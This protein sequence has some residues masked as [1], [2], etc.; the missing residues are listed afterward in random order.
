[1]KIQAVMVAAA[2]ACGMLVLASGDEES[3]Q[4]PNVLVIMTDEHNFRTLGCYRERL[5]KEEAFVWGEG[6]AVETPHIDSLA[7]SGAVC[8]RFYAASPVCTPSRAAFFSGRYPQNTGAFKNDLPLRDDVVTFAEALRRRGYATGYAGKW[9]LDGDAKP[10]WAP[11]RKFGF[12]DNACMFNRGHWKQFEDTAS[13]P[14]VK[15]RD[16]RGE[17][18]YDVAGADAR[19]FAT[20][21]LADKAVAF[22][23]RHAGE[24][25]CFVVSFPDPHGPNTVRAAYDRMYAD[26]DIRRPASALQNGEGLPSWATPPAKPQF[27]KMAEYFGM[28]KCIDD[29]VG[30]IMGALCEAGLSGRTIV[31]FTADHGDMCGEHGRVNKGIPLEGSARIPFVLA[32]PGKIRP[33]TVIREA[34]NNVDFKPTLLGLLGFPGDPL[35]EGKDASRLLIA[36]ER[37]AGWNGVTF[38]RNS[39]GSWLMAVTEHH[40]F[41]VSTGDAPC[42]FDLRGDPF[43]MRNICFEPGSR[44]IVRQLAMALKQYAEKTREPGADHAAIRADLEWASGEGENY[45][46]GERTT[47]KQGKARRSRKQGERRPD[48]D[49]VE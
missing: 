3:A 44:Q 13:G 16:R 1:M 35:D 33:G 23:K 11:A 9:H 24:P 15:A 6:I 12:E 17:P 36:G 5:P 18:T 7:H 40:K 47:T 20:D 27:E 25:F 22:M 48:N 28:V 26:L 42:L 43:E 49:G 37:P 39:S 19:S 29:N 2:V 31:V 4:P 10:G 8:E 14:A 38:S 45:P 21:F 34:L 41:V 46:P 30:K 32:Y